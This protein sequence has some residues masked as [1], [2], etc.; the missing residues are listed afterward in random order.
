MISFL[1]Y[2]GIESF[3]NRPTKHHALSSSIIKAQEDPRILYISWERSLVNTVRYRS[4]CALAAARK[5]WPFLYDTFC[6]D[7]D[8]L[9]AKLQAIHHVLDGPAEYG[10]AVRCILEEQIL[11]GGN[12]NGKTGKYASLYHPTEGLGS[13]TSLTGSRPLTVGEITAHWKDDLRDT[14]RFRYGPPDPLESLV[15]ATQDVTEQVSS[16]MSFNLYEEA[17]ESGA[18]VTI[19]SVRYKMD[20]PV[21]VATLEDAGVDHVL[22]DDVTQVESLRMEQPSPSSK[23]TT[24]LILDDKSDTLQRL[25]ELAPTTRIDCV[26]ASYDRL[27]SY[28]SLCGD[29]AHRCGSL[30]RLGLASWATHPD[31]ILAA[32]ANPWINTVE[33]S[34]PSRQS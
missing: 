31:E 13:S 22:V 25:L 17:L 33:Q 5:L 10:L 27:Q 28:T 12:S 9:F 23:P 15:M 14:L 34:L 26:E 18:A 19:I 11:D 24:V 30:L 7:T 6:D 16:R 21:A 8:W 29:D 1:T 3:S 20:L 2:Q 32:T 4:E